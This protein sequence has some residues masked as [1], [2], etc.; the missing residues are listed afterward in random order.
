MVSFG[1]FV[2]L[3]FGF[4]LDKKTSF[5]LFYV[6]VV[7]YNISK[8][9]SGEGCMRKSGINSDFGRTKFKLI[10]SVIT[11]GEHIAFH[12]YSKFQFE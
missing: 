3:M 2:Q 7:I 8:N 4:L 10:M 6:P 12:N 9:V 5:I 1:Y 11:P